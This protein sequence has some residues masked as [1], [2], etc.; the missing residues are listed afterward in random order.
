LQNTHSQWLSLA[1]RKTGAVKTPHEQPR[2]GK[3]LYNSP[4]TIQS[5]EATATPY[6][7]NVHADQAQSAQKKTNYTAAPE[8]LCF[9]R[10]LN[11]GITIKF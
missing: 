1:L 10:V 2:N 9:Q 8:P 6:I 11:S 4:E 3:F 5:V 7:N